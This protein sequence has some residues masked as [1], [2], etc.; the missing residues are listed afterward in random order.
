MY[1]TV[2]HPG[3]KNA[4]FHRGGGYDHGGMY[5]MM[6]AARFFKVCS[7]CYSVVPTTLGVPPHHAQLVHIYITDA[8][9][10]SLYSASHSSL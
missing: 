2:I 10:I 3:D 8:G 9:F 5:Q 6:S 4:A 7:L 1:L